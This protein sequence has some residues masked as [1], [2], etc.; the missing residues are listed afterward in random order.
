MRKSSF[1]LVAAA[2][3]I[4]LAV[5]GCSSSG[6]SA[7]NTDTKFEIFT[8]WS[9]GGEAAGLQGMIDVYTAQNPNT[10]FINA[11]VAGG[12][13][14][15]AKAVLA[16]RLEANDAPD[17][18]QAHAG[19]EL[20]GYVRSGKLEDLTSLYASEGWDKV[21]PA[22]LIKTLT[23]DGKIYSVPVN[24][25]RA[26]VIWWNPATATKAGITAAPAT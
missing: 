9:S 12:A 16:S 23:V 15:N 24:I 18:F 20:D 13:G 11:A 17:S 10:E 1:R 2:A 14:V 26:N 7:A 4:A 19:M 3:A 5:T 8:W 6:D 25:H 22:D 21:F